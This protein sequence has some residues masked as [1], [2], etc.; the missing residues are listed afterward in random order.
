MGANAYR[1]SIAWPRI[2]PEGRGKPNPK[3]V[4]HYKR[5]ADDLLENGIEPYVTLFH[6]DL[7]TALPGDWRSRDTAYAFA[8]YAGFMAGQLADR[9]AIS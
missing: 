2:F 7:P 4:D 9:C 1:F 6:W 5:V 3:G 8:D